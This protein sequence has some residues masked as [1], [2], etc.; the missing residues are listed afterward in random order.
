M[1]E[2][3]LE[4]RR[5]TAAAAASPPTLVDKL[6]AAQRATA[7][8]VA[9]EEACARDIY[10]G[11]AVATAR[12]EPSAAAVA[13]L[14]KA[15]ETL[16]WTPAK[17]RQDIEVLQLLD[18][19]ASGKYLQPVR[20]ARE[21]EAAARA[22]WTEAQRRL[23][24]AKV[25]LA[26]AEQSVSETSWRRSNAAD[27]VREAE[28]ICAADPKRVYD[29]LPMLRHRGCPTEVLAPLDAD[30]LVPPKPITARMLGEAVVNGLYRQRGDLVTLDEGAFDP[31]LMQR[32]D[33]PLPT[34][35][36]RVQQDFLDGQTNRKRVAGDVYDLPPGSD[37][38][39]NK[40]ILIVV[41][42]DT[43]LRTGGVPGPTRATAIVD[44][45]NPS[46]DNA[47]VASAIDGD[48]DGEP[49]E[50]NGA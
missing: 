14:E 26:A 28:R 23:D 29:E 32:G 39:D 35:R 24:A 5:P 48:G 37:V 16:G 1:T 43:P 9:A 4:P 6:E 46:V 21:A 34:I 18:S 49:G 33:G 19:V 25:E 2:S 13:D 38:P 50:E 15:L 31:A 47:I 3:K 41:P 36:V 8:R 12:G 27:A 7:E 45:P 40:G 17:L 42:S 30:R 10:W 22:A 11:A 20:E 44:S